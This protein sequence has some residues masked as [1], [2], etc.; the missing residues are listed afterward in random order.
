MRASLAPEC[1][2]VEVVGS[3]NVKTFNTL[4]TLSLRSQPC[5]VI[6]ALPERLVSIHTFLTLVFAEGGYPFHLFICTLKVF[7]FTALADN[8]KLQEGR[9]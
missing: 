1:D 9:A 3:S 2:Y 5:V 8:L 6:G 7:S 4:V